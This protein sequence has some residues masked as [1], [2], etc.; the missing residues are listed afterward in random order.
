VADGPR[1][2]LP[3]PEHDTQ[4]YWDAARDGKLLIRRC[5]ACGEASFYPRPFCPECWSNDVDWETATGRA[6]L[7]TW[8][9]EIGRA[10]V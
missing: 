4:P 8:S 6:T 7:Y 10:H 1:F 5:R 3:T 2:D 9:V